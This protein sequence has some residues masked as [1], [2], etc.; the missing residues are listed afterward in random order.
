MTPDEALAA[1]AAARMQLFQASQRREAVILRRVRIE[2]PES[3]DSI[4][5][6][7]V[8]SRSTVMA[9]TATAQSVLAALGLGFPVTPAPPAPTPA[10][11]PPPTPAPPAPTP[12]PTPGAPAS[13][14]G[15]P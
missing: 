3:L 7:I 2:A 4:N 6:D 13:A 10:P 15:A 1:L 9:A 14:P 11:T 8:N 12:A 5:A